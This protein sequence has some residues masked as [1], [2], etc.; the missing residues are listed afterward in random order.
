M[1]KREKSIIVRIN[2][3]NLGV[4][5]LDKRIKLFVFLYIIILCIGIYFQRLGH[6]KNNALNSFEA[7]KGYVDLSLWDEDRDLV[8]LKGEWEFYWKKLLLPNDLVKLDKPIQYAFVPKSWEEMN[9]PV[10]GYATYRL[11][12]SGLDPKS[13]YGFKILDQVTAYKIWVN[14]EL[15]ASNGN[16]SDN[17]KEHRPQWKSVIKAFQSDRQGKA[18]VVVQVSNFSYYR[19]GLWN[20]IRIGKINKIIEA[21]ESNIISE[22]FQFTSIFIVGLYYFSQYIVFETEKVFLYYSL[23][24]FSMS[25]RILLKGERLIYEIMNMLPWEIHVKFEYFS[26]YL[27]LPLFSLFFYYLYKN[28]VHK[29]IKKSSYVMIVVVMIIIGFPEDFYPKLLNIYMGMALVYSIYFIYFLIKNYKNR[30]WDSTIILI[31]IITLCISIIKDLFFG[32]EYS[33]V[34]YGFLVFILNFSIVM[35]KKY[36][37]TIKYTK[38]LELKIKLDPLTNLYNRGYFI[39]VID[40]K[41]R[42]KNQEFS[43]LF[44]DLDNFKKVNDLYGHEVGDEVLRIVAKRLKHITRHKDMVGRYGG[45]EFLIYVEGNS[46]DYISG[47]C[48][49]IIKSITSPYRIGQ[50]TVYIGVSIGISMYPKDGLDMDEII[51]KS[52]KAM[53]QAKRSGG[54]QFYF[55][56]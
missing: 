18:E 34:S 39:N 28:D 56:K 37:D 33:F 20:D 16:V 43:I 9:L 50:I 5:V 36:S 42:N 49:R 24:C 32:G 41:H 3:S 25:S 38:T 10:K 45:D 14:G 12:I 55:Y 48:D 54:N 51:V 31:G 26:G 22:I 15:L 23:F 2:N 46:Y 44:L 1:K 13:I 6:E 17:L 19:G 27:L 53:Y 29:L 40:D 8:N 30:K 35:A 47:I 21:K 7:Q 52:D 4:I 11:K